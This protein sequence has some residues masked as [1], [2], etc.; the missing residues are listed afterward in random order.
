MIFFFNNIFLKY[1]NKDRYFLIQATKVTSSRKQFRK[2]KKKKKKKKHIKRRYWNDQKLKT[3]QSKIVNE[4]F[5]L[6]GHYK[7][8]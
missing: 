8:N 3:F 7:C 4:L 2:L 5:E 1:C 6:Y